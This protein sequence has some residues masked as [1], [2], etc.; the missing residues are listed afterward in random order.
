MDM[1][2]QICI[3]ENGYY[4]TNWNN[5]EWVDFLGEMPCIDPIELLCAY[6]YNRETKDLELDEERIS[7]LRKEYD[8]EDPNVPSIEER[9][10]AVEG[11][12]LDM[13]SKE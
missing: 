3:D 9:L 7:K 4:T 1:K 6:K 5:S 2:P 13:L 11:L 12:M 8:I 10:S